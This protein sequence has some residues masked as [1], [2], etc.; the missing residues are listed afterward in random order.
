[1][2]DFFVSKGRIRFAPNLSLRVLNPAAAVSRLHQGGL[3][4][5]VHCFHCMPCG[6][7]A[8]SLSH[9]CCMGISN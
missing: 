2:K 5:R 1:M 8:I 4:I 7:Q 9:K 6:S 3:N